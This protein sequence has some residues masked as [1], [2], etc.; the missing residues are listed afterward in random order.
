MLLQRSTVRVRRPQYYATITH[1]KPT[2]TILR[3]HPFVQSRRDYAS[4]T[5]GKVK[6]FM[7][8]YGPVGVGVYLALSVVDLGLTMAVISV[9]GADKVMEAEDYVWSKIKGCLV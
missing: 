7:K 6:G 2:L 9:K 5:G 8:K 3:P 1:P 4:Q